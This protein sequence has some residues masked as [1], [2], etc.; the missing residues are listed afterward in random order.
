L[1]IHAEFAGSTRESDYPVLFFLQPIATELRSVF[2]L[3]G[4]IGNLFFQLDRYLHLP[5]ELTWIVHDLPF[6]REAMVEFAKKKGEDR[7][8]F[9]DEFSRAS[10]VDLF[11]VVG[12]VHY[13]EPPLA[14]L[15]ARLETLPRH[16]IV[17]RSPFSAANDVIAVQ[18]G[19]LWLSACKLH[20]MDR[21]CSAMGDL[22]YS[23]V[24][25]WPVHERRMRVP[26]FPDCGAGYFGF[27]FRLSA[28]VTVQD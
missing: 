24:A 27:Y 3:G 7:V 15:L 14:E 25:K 11:I 5:R 13:F 12:A 6:K 2:D 22:G 10:G 19:G 23:L 21:F 1:D 18:D 26:L 4:S 9:S 28:A 16:V 8:A 20:R 17:N